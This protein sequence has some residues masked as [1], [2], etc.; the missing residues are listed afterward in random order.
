MLGIARNLNA[1][2]ARNGMKFSTFSVQ[3]FSTFSVQLKSVLKYTPD[4]EWIQ[5]DN[6]VGTF[7]ITDYAQKGKFKCIWKKR[8]KSIWE[9]RFNMV[10]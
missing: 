3:L 1:L 4:H 2:Q 7:G 9:K 5:V 8:F 6:G 10:K